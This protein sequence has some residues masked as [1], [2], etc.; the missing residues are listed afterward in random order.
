MCD[1]P[2][3]ALY[4]MTYALTPRPYTLVESTVGV[5][6]PYS[7]SMLFL[8]VDAPHFT[9]SF[10]PIATS[11]EK[12]ASTA[13]MLPK[14]TRFPVDDSVILVANVT[15]LPAPVGGALFPAHANAPFVIEKYAAAALLMYL[16]VAPPLS[17]QLEPSVTAPLLPSH[18]DMDPPTP[19]WIAR[20]VDIHALGVTL[21][22]TWPVEAIRMVSVLL[23][24]HTCD[25]P[26]PAL[27]RMV[28]AFTP[29]PYTSV[30]ATVGVPAPYSISMLFWV[31]NAPHR[32]I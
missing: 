20:T 21:M 27:Y 15:A 31:V 22:P 10:A 3:S 8:I 12:L 17:Y 25:A 26:P 7:I 14:T 29:R 2:V 23:T 16:I 28:N 5:P 1:A 6:A 18:V 4:R 30:E 24:Y 11:P 13:L 19:T 9:I 32:S